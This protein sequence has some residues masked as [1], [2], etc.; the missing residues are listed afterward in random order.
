MST[1]WGKHISSAIVA[2]HILRA[3]T[4]PS[5]VK[6]TNTAW[7]N[8]SQD[9][10]DWIHQN[11][12][13]SSSYSSSIWIISTQLYALPKQDGKENALDRAR[14]SENITLLDTA[15][16]NCRTSS[17]KQRWEWV[18][19]VLGWSLFWPKMEESVRHCISVRCAATE[20]ILVNYLSWQSLAVPSISSSL[21]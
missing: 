13:A 3:A 8:K 1:H 4:I 19:N 10:R 14:A 12:A 9:W 21:R 20:C 17:F 2:G 5:L 18:G 15:K 11:V 6:Q 7:L 16:R